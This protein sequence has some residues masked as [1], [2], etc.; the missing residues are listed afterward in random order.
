MKKELKFALFTVISAAVL[1]F[2]LGF[3]I[4]VFDQAVTPIPNGIANILSYLLISATVI[5][6]AG[7]GKF[8]TRELHAGKFVG[9]V[10]I[11][12][13]V[14]QIIYYILIFNRLVG[15]KLVGQDP[16]FV[17]GAKIGFIVGPIL[18]YML[19]TW[20]GLLLSRSIQKRRAMKPGQSLNPAPTPAPTPIAPVLPTESKATTD[21]EVPPTTTA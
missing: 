13:F 21:S 6:V 5:L 14:L 16:A 19:F 18:V 12:G 17:T 1:T 4:G 2:L 10:A 7:W 9:A 11:V 20:L 15:P 3:I 8:N